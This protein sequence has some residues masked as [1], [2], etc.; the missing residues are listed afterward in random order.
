MPPDERASNEPAPGAAES[1]PPR[2]HAAPTGT[3]AAILSAAR[4]LFSTHGF[5]GTSIADIASAAGLAPGTIYIHFENKADLLAKVVQ[6]TRSPPL[7]TTPEELAGASRPEMFTL[8]ARMTTRETERRG[9][10]LMALA[11]D[12]SR[13]VEV[14]QDFYANTLLG[15]YESMEALLASLPETEGLVP[16]DLRVLAHVILNAAIFTTI[17]Q[18]YLGGDELH[19]VETERLEAV[20]GALAALALDNAAD[21]TPGMQ[22][23]HEGKRNP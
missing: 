21:L 2:R 18:G 1:E 20:V 7:P 12:A 10:Y 6:E 9:E 23:S 4:R 5:E 19:H 11:S 13:T 15:V 16:A 22:D 3:R 8:L 17:E 14:R